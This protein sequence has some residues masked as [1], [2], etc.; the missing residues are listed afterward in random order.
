MN[1]NYNSFQKI[2]YFE[3]K[4]AQWFNAPY[5]VAVDCCTHGLELCLRYTEAPLI[6]TPINTYI[7]VPLL[8]K[9]LSID[10]QWRS[11]AWQSFYYITSNIIDAAVLWEKNSYINNTFMVLSFQ[12]KKHLSLGRG[13]MILTDN[14]EAAIK[15][16]KMSYD[17]R[18]FD[19]PWTEQDIDTIGYH[20]YMTPETAEIG[21]TKLEEAIIKKPKLWSYL[22]YPDLTN[23]K[24]FNNG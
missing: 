17:G 6:S 10:L 13:G 23:L 15:L 3:K 14:K 4:V 22:D 16:R 21:L 8:S 24:V 5:G 19:K 9:K 12:F 20:Y 11:F 2:T 1:T 7:S 18:T